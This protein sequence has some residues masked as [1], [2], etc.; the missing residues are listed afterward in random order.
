MSHC[1]G[2]YSIK[3]QHKILIYHNILDAISMIR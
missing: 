2:S 1:N 3:W